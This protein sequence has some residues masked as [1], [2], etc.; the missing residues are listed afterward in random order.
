MASP[1]S[2]RLSEATAA[3]VEGLS[4]AP[5]RRRLSADAADL[6]ASTG[7]SMLVR[8]PTVEKGGFRARIGLAGIARRTLGICLL[9]LTV[10]LWTLSNFLASVS[11]SIPSVLI[12]RRTRLTRR[13]RSLYFPTTLTISPSSSSTSTRPSSQCP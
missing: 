2:R 4:L 10:F 13:R 12:H 11:P 1:G 7:S 9:L 6:A 8:V 3:E 5:E